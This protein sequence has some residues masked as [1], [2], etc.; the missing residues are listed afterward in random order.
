MNVQV[1]AKTAT[2]W[3]T[4]NLRRSGFSESSQ[5]DVTV[6]EIYEVHAIALWSESVYYQIIGESGILAWI[7]SSVFRVLDHSIPS[8]WLINQIDDE[9]PLILGPKF[10]VLSK[11]AYSDMVELVPE[12]VAQFKDRLRRREKPPSPDLRS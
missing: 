7:P 8:D 12:K 4:D 3:L 5:L 1:A 6:M 10:M 9:V 11:E 2:D